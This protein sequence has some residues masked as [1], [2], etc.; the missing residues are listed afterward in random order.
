MYKNKKQHRF[1]NEGQRRRTIGVFLVFGVCFCMLLLRMV[2]FMVWQD[3]KLVKLT[4]RQEHATIRLNSPRGTIYDK[5]RRAL[6]VSINVPSVY[7]DPQKADLSPA[8]IKKLAKALSLSVKDIENKLSRKDRR[9]VWIKRKINPDKKQEIQSLSLDGIGFVSEWD[10]FYPNREFAS[11]VIGFVNLDGKG[12]EGLERQYEAS[13]FSHVVELQSQKDAR[14]RLILYGDHIHMDRKKGFD[15]VLTLDSVLQYFLEEEL[16]N[17]SL[18]SSVEAGFGIIMD[19]NTGA[20]L[21]MASYPQ[22]NPNRIDRSTAASRK[23]RNLLDTFEPGSTFK[24][25]VMAQALENDLVDP[26][27]V[28]NC[29]EGSLRIGKKVIPNP[30]DKD[31]LDAQGILKFS[32]NVCM[33]TIGMDLGKQGMMEMIQNFGFDQKTGIDFPYE[34]AGYFDADRTWRDMRLA[35]LAFGQGIGVTSMQMVRAMAAIA[36]GGYRV[37]P[38]FVQE[39]IAG[40]GEKVVMT[41]MNERVRIMSSKTS[42]QMKT[43]LMHVTDEDGTGK[44]ARVKGYEVAGKTGTAQIYDVETHSYSHEKVVSSFLGFAPAKDPQMVAFVVLV[45]PQD[46]EHGGTIAAPVFQR[47]MTK[48]LPYME[49]QAY[50]TSLAYR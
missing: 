13:L 35:N 46:A 10:R 31:M 18:A 8:Q 40:T 19:P 28:M 6:A 23:N 7:A 50:H 42:E 29:K 43:F 17:A 14:G 30:V 3:E 44:N 5:H 33:A 27:K 21:A 24:A 1:G 45:Q 25:F 4:H 26:A 38:H 20:V 32:N 22:M 12:M 48:A 49:G 15:L 37:Q 11:Q 36:N 16:V 41:P 2:T 9:F 34:S 47:F 39:M